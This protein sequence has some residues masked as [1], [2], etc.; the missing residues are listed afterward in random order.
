MAIKQGARAFVEGTAGYL[1][2][3]DYYQDCV[4]ELDSFFS[5]GPYSLI[6]NET[7]FIDIKRGG[8]TVDKFVFHFDG[9]GDIDEVWI[10]GNNKYAI[11]DSCRRRRQL[12]GL[13]V[14]SVSN[15]TDHV[16]ITITDHS[17]Y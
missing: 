6:G 2:I 7:L 1:S 16:E 5:P 17:V 15:S 14:G 3:I 12:W 13:G 4:V 8:Q 10:Y 9:A 11:A